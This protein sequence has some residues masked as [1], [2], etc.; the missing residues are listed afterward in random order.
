MNFS[1]L[2]IDGIPAGFTNEQLRSLF[3]PYGTVLAA[4]VLEADT[5]PPTGLVE[6]ATM[7]EA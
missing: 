3:C 1:R 6:V 5:L 2:I 4:T 7:E